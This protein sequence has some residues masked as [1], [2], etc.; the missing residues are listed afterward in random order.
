MDRYTLSVHLAAEIF[1]V[2][3]THSPL[4]TVPAVAASHRRAGIVAVA[5]FVGGADV[6]AVVGDVY[7]DHYVF[8]VSSIIS[9]RRR[10]RRHRRKR[11]RPLKSGNKFP[12]FVFAGNY[13]T[14]DANRPTGG[15]REF[16]VR[17]TIIP[18]NDDGGPEFRVKSTRK[19]PRKLSFFILCTEHERRQRQQ[20][21]IVAN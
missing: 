14:T 19:I 12:A 21:Q 10:R 4:F 13:R 3:C 6:A 11:N 1:W 2:A 7:V 5:P 8:N 17:K 9:R 20:S 15:Q 18:D 16:C